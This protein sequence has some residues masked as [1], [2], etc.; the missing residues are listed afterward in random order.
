L[1]TRAYVAVVVL[2]SALPALLVGC[3]GGGRHY[4]DSDGDGFD[5]NED[6][7][8]L[9]AEDFNG[10]ADTDGCPDG[11]P[12]VC[13][14][15]Q[16]FGVEWEVDTGNRVPLT[17]ATTPLSH[18]EVVTNA[19]QILVVSNLAEDCDD[20]EFYNWFGF[21]QGQIP[22]GTTI[23]AADLVSDVDD[24]LLSTLDVPP[25]AQVAIGNCVPAYY[26]FEFPLN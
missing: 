1:S 15:N 20:R 11:S 23:V 24:T 22:V 6:R 13:L 19:N 14:P 8:P 2:A 7:C 12:A 17:C 25:V 4:P 21:T 26:T 3:G 18:V 5:D 16:A 9:S 10:I